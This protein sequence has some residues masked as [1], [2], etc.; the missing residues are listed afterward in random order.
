VCN[1]NDNGTQQFDDGPS[2]AILMYM[3]LR[4][5]GIA[6]TFVVLLAWM[7]GRAPVALARTQGAVASLEYDTLFYTHDELKLEAYLYKPTGAGPFPLVVYNHGSAEPGQERKE[8]A[9]P[10]IARI[11][12][13]AGYALLVPERRGYGKSEGRAFSEEIGSERGRKFVARQQ[14]EATDINAAIEYV[15]ALPGSPIDPKRIAMVG[16]SFGGIVTTLASS[17]SAR[18]VSIVVQAPGALNWDRSVELRQALT[19]AAAKI[20][21]PIYCAVAEN[22]ATTESARAIC[23]AA[24]RNGAKA[25]LTVYPSFDRGKQRPGNPPGHAL[26]GPSGVDIWQKDLLTFLA[27]TTLR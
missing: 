21:R 8:W 3:T 16:W 17:Q 10:F 7:V 4:H 23:A 22:D 20:Q 9:A 12:V 27:E 19:A 14:A 26:F 6:I 2:G 15:I 18:V 13:P 25:T 24:T 5:P 11:L 1:V